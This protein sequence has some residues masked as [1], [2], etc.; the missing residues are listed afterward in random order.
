MAW[1]CYAQQLKQA[2]EVK[3]AQTAAAE[4]GEPERAAMTHLLHRI[5]ES[6]PRALALAQEGKDDGLAPMVD[7]LTAVV[8]RKDKL[9][10][11]HL[12]A[13][14]KLLEPCLPLRFIEWCLTQ[15][16]KVSLARCCRR[17]R[18]LCMLSSIW[19][20]TACGTRCSARS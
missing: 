10:A 12:D 8:A 11:L 4:S 5:V 16:D 9:T 3:A 6:Q 2:Q 7:E 14:E 20:R 13:V 17:S 15:S 18:L 19:I 1:L